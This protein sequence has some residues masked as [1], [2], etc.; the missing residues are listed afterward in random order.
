MSLRYVGQW[1]FTVGAMP[2]VRRH[3]KRCLDFPVSP[4]PWKELAR[5]RESGKWCLILFEMRKHKGL[6]RND[7]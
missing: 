1:S 5:V 6:W 3:G 7:R 2:C 4:L